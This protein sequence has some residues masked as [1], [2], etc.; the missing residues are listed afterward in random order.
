M[1]IR[2][3][4]RKHESNSLF[5]F[6]KHCQWFPT[7][8]MKKFKSFG[9]AQSALCDLAHLLLQFLRLIDGQSTFLLSW[10]FFLL[11]LILI[12]LLGSSLN[13]SSVGKSAT[14]ET[15]LASDY[16][17]LHSLFSVLLI[18]MTSI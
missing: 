18:M 6:L 11:W 16:A 15:R 5:L 8:F 14:L 1:A 2:E 3:I 9:L 17:N 12:H 7:S 10:Q 13:I 4:F